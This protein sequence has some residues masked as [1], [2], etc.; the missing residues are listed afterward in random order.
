MQQS[1]TEWKQGEKRERSRRAKRR[2]DKDG[3]TE[4]KLE[5]GG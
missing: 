5:R 2:N 1:V 4:G 3:W